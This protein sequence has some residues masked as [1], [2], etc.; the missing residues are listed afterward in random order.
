MIEHIMIISFILFSIWTIWYTWKN[1]RDITK[2][3]KKLIKTDYLYF[4]C[5]KYVNAAEDNNKKVM[6]NTVCELRYE[7][8]END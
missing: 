7:L 8:K 4:L 1:A 5:L 3:Q 6:R 2:V